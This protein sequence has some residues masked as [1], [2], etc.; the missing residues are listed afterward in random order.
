MVK[1][2]CHARHPLL[3]FPRLISYL[4]LLNATG[5]SVK[6]WDCSEAINDLSIDSSATHFSP[7]KDKVG[8][9][10]LRVRFVDCPLGI[11]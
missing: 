1:G 8:V 5:C 7:R 2:I 10:L 4:L 11:P 3:S 6:L 9:S